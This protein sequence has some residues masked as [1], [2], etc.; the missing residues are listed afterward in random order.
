MSS[1]KTGSV[2]LESEPQGALVFENGVFT[3]HETDVTLEDVAEG[4]HIYELQFDFYDDGE[5]PHQIVVDVVAGQLVTRFVDM[6]EEPQEIVPAPNAAPQHLEVDRPIY[7]GDDNG[8]VKVEKLTD[9]SA[10]S[11]IV[12]GFIDFYVV[13]VLLS[14][15]GGFFGM[16]SGSL[17][18]GVYLLLR[19]GLFGN[20]QSI[21]K[22]ALGYHVLGP[23]GRVCS[24]ED[25]AVRNW[26]L[27]IGYLLSAFL[28]VF[29]LYALYFI[30][31]FL[32]MFL[33]VI[34]FMLVCVDSRGL[35]LGDRFANTVVRRG[36]AS[37]PRLPAGNQG[38]PMLE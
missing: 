19:D 33:L 10:G 2:R 9:V 30:L 34:E 17:L 25:S 32:S 38:P 16:F 31:S 20:G 26:P 4:R 8:E 15:F 35:R 13:G 7:I 1:A 22:M 36:S 6:G 37:L 27:A 12:A 3:G 29:G 28:S 18:P 24:L 23:E 5:L 11:R 14:L 21:G